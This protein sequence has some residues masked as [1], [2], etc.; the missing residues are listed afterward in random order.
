MVCRVRGNVVYDVKGSGTYLTRRSKTHL[1]TGYVWVELQKTYGVAF[2]TR[3]TNEL[4]QCVDVQSVQLL[5]ESY[6]YLGSEPI[7][8]VPS[9]KI[10]TGFFLPTC[11]VPFVKENRYG[12]LDRDR[13]LRQRKWRQNDQDHAIEEV[14]TTQG[15]VPMKP[16]GPINEYDPITNHLILPDSWKIGTLV[17][18]P[19]TDLPIDISKIVFQTVSYYWDGAV[20]RFVIPE[21]CRGPGRF[22]LKTRTDLQKMN[23]RLYWR[24]LNA[25]RLGYVHRQDDESRI[26]MTV[27][28]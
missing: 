18:M 17:E 21:H 12:Y 11:D 24:V 26:C 27:R 4:Q 20:M 19:R 14:M 22:L 6:T 3:F 13:G 10:G 1:P 23:L 5:G 2:V 28:L 16:D 9:T 25:G 15:R 8:L 7:D